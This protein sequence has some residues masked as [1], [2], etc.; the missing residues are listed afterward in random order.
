MFRRKIGK[1]NSKLT[2][3]KDHQSLNETNEHTK[4]KEIRVIKPM[5]VVTVLPNL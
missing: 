2:L 4:K 1:Q 5:K 3:W